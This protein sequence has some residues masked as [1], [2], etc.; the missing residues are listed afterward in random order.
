LPCAGGLSIDRIVIYIDD[1]DRCPP[2][3]V[4][5]VLQVVQLLLAQPLFVVVIAAEPRWLYSSLCLRYPTLMKE[6]SLTPRQYLEKI[7]QLP[8]Q[9]PLMQAGGF[10]RLMDKYL[11]QVNRIPTGAAG[12]PGDLQLR[13]ST[14]RGS[15]PDGSSASVQQT[16][17]QAV[18]LEAHEQTFMKSLFCLLVTPRAS[19]RFSN[20]YRFIRA[21]ARELELGRLVGT[22]AEGGEYEAVQVMLA[23]TCGFPTVAPGFFETLAYTNS[24]DFRDFVE[25]DLE[26]AFL[27]AGF[28]KEEERLMR[29][30]C[31]RLRSLDNLRVGKQIKPYQDWAERVAR[32]TFTS[33]QDRWRV[34]R[35]VHGGRSVAN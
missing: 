12:L 2:E 30:I 4:V 15:Q 21:S 3:R 22:A 1:L 14:A 11:P 23:L 20:L 28:A 24:K 26:P 17:A 34:S 25:K 19:L 33:G 29:A 10:G 16:T 6:K 32:H 31:D 8:I 35:F 9:V 18:V 5:D 27:G 13:G 7:I